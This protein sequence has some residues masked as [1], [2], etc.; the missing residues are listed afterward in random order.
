MR[1]T[2]AVALLAL[3]CGAAAGAQ[4]LEVHLTRSEPGG[5][6]RT[7]ALYIATP[8]GEWLYFDMAFEPFVNGTIRPH[9]DIYLVG[10]EGT[11]IAL[12]DLRTY[13]ANREEIRGVF[14][15]IATS[16]AAGVFPVAR[17]FPIDCTSHSVGQAGAGE[18]GDGCE[19][20]ALWRFSVGPVA[21]VIAL[22]R[23]ITV[24]TELLFRAPPG[25]WAAGDYVLT[26]DG[27]G[28][29]VTRLPVR[30]G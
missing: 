29:S 27:P 30:I 6:L 19:R 5:P 14:G 10:P 18:G 8:I 15:A 11:R 1:R 7:G 3:A 9:R 2:L 12:P 13:R 22:N 26:I 16:D 17:Q 20:Y 23:G 21:R 28:D 25:G 24:Q 4:S